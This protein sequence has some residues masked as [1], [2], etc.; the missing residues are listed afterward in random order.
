MIRRIPIVQLLCANLQGC[1]ILDFRIYFSGAKNEPIR[2]G[3]GNLNFT[4][5]TFPSAISA[6]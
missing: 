1:A 3:M 6:A 2:D 4:I 5:Y